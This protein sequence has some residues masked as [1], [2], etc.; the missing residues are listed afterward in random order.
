MNIRPA[1]LTPFAVAVL[2]SIGCR[3][4]PTPI[5][6]YT[7]A[8][9]LPMD[10]HSH[11][12]PN[13]VR[14][15]HVRLDLTLDFEQQAAHG[16]VELGLARN[17]SEAPVV[18]DS[19]GLEIE[20]VRGGDGGARTWDLGPEDEDLGSALTIALEPEDSSV[21]VVYR[22]TERGQAMQWLGPEQTADGTHPFLFTQGQSILTRSW[23]PLQDSPG[24]RVT[25]EA[26][27]RAPEGMTAVMS[28]E[29]LG[30]KRGV[31][32]FRMPQAIPPYL[33]AL[34]CGS[35]E[36]GK[37]S[38]RCGVYAEPSL[39]DAARDELD[40]TEAM[41]ATAEQ[42]FGP[43]RWGRYDMIVLPP[44]FPFGGMENP[45]LTFLTPTMLAGDKSLVALIA[46]EL[47]HSW[48]GNLVTNATWRDF[49]LNEGTTVY[50]EQRIM[51]VVYGR[52]RS[53]MEKVLSLRELE[54]EMAGMDDRDEI[55]WI[56]LTGRHP[57]E[58]FSGVPY[59]KG[60][61]FLRRLEELY[62]RATF[63]AFLIGYFDAHAFESITTPE[64][65][66]YLTANL[67]SLDPDRGRY[68]GVETWLYEP[69]LPSSTP[70]PTSVKLEQVDTALHSL[71]MAKAPDDMETGNWVTQQWLH[72]LEGLPD[73][74]SPEQM[75][76]LDGVFHF[77]ASGNNEILAV[78]LRLSIH[79]GYEAAY[80]RLEEFLMT[81]GRRKFLKPLYAELAKSS[82]G[83]GW[84]RRVYASARPR[85]HAVSTG[86]IDEILEWEG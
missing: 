4:E 11:S 78:W 81:V 22:T 51:E 12:R 75:A 45:R 14:V 77:T 69:G 68:A 31:W 49:W 53:D 24:V 73:S 8:R 17:D 44:A 47:A 74:M 16:L 32:R 23:I 13:E 64:F 5:V 71:W 76:E 40:D 48:S 34:A 42:L 67:L 21:V 7:P 57:D 82:E 84:A 36:F 29:Q 56:D 72:F 9:P 20:E 10:V 54:A 86:T 80:P 55:L 38:D 35:L 62:G 65:E 59:E 39:V 19:L 28:A 25:Y 60:A 1:G 66:D 79:N 27:I 50:L 37:I 15:T 43:Y 70:R 83:L 85:Y 46:H 18:L 61:L 2:A 6:I 30:R 3:S 41:I 52:A 26:E 58:G 33:I 63:D